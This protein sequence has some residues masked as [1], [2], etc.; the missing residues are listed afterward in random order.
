[1]LA[2]QSLR[3][4]WIPPIMLLACVCSL[5][6]RVPRR[7]EAAQRRPVLIT[8]DRNSGWHPKTITTQWRQCVVTSFQDEGV[9]L[10][11]TLGTISALTKT[12]DLCVAGVNNKDVSTPFVVD[13]LDST[14]HVVGVCLYTDSTRSAQ[15]GLGTPPASADH[16]RK[17]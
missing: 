3:N 17:P 13:C 4:V 8:A 2:T 10:M 11:K 5:T 7:A 14:D 15:A 12:N 1:M 6:L 9:T 16:C